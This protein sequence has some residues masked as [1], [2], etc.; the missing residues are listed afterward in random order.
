MAPRHCL[1]GSRPVNTAWSHLQVSKIPWK[2]DISTTG[3]PPNVGHF[4]P[5]G[6]VA[7]PKRTETTRARLLFVCSKPFW[8]ITLKNHT[9][10]RNKQ[11]N[12]S[13][14]S[15]PLMV[16]PIN[17]TPSSYWLASPKLERY[18]ILTDTSRSKSLLGATEHGRHV[19][20]ASL[21]KC[22]E[23]KL[24]IFWGTTIDIF[25]GTLLVMVIR[26]VVEHCVQLV[27]IYP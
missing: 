9:R 5:T 27:A 8:H 15:L 22:E 17:N 20:M 1:I 3:I 24:K 4:S 11:Q 7:H 13:L 2:M 6:V 16:K 23:N 21:S 26:D 19:L 25:G 18:F 14:W 12:I 10:P